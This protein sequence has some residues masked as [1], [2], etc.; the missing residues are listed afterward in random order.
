MP[1]VYQEIPHNFSEV[2]SCFYTSKEDIIRE[3]I[4]SKKCFFYDTCSFRTHAN[5]KADD[6]EFI[7]QHIKNSGGIIVI[8]GTVLMELGSVSGRLNEEYMA[9]F[10]NINEF[11]IP[12][13]L[14]YEEHL[15]DVLSFCFSAN[16]RVNE[17]LTWAV[18]MVRNPVSTITETLA[19]DRFL[20]REVVEVRGSD[21]STLFSRFFKAVRSNKE[22]E[23][24][25]G[26]EMIAVCLHLLTHL[27]GEPDGKYCMITDDKDAAGRVS[28]LL[29]QTRAQY[30]GSKVY[31]LSTPKLVQVMNRSGSL[32]DKSAITEIL[33][34]SAPG[35]VKIHGTRMSDLRAKDIS[36]TCEELAD[37]ILE[38]NGINIIF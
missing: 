22:S 1:T 28:T 20:R 18:R 12:A 32:T 37:L 30:Q 25:L 13:V 3:I 11:G 26:E 34:V 27:P 8:T 9:Y 36:M 16:S 2:E 17:Y 35:N 14:L 6:A 24:D 15:F 23:D 19:A 7:L 10:H 5:L 31:I 38:P 33:K 4:N 21:S 29:E